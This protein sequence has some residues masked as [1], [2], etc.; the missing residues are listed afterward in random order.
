MS[1]LVSGYKLFSA[2]TIRDI[3]NYH[4]DNV[5]TAEIIFDNIKEFITLSPE[6]TIYYWNPFNKCF[7]SNDGKKSYN[8]LTTL[9]LSLFSVSIRSL[10]EADLTTLMTNLKIECTQSLLDKLD[11]SLSLREKKMMIFMESPNVR[12]FFTD[13]KFSSIENQLVLL[14]QNSFAFEL[15]VETDVMNFHNGIINLRTG[16]FRDRDPAIDKY[17]KCLPYDYKPRDMIDESIV[18][19]I[20]E[21][22][23]R[24]CNNDPAYYEYIMTWIGYCM[25]GDVGAEKYMVI[26]GEG[27]NAKSTIFNILNDIFPIYCTL[28]Q[29]NAFEEGCNNVHKILDQFNRPMRCVYKDEISQKNKIDDALIKQLVSG[30]I[31]AEVLFATTKSWKSHAKITMLGNY[32]PVIDS[33]YASTRRF[34]LAKFTSKFVGKKEMDELHKEGVKNVFLADIFF[35]KKFKQEKYRDAFVHIVLEFCKKFYDN[36]ATGNKDDMFPIP[37]EQELI[38]HNIEKIQESPI[39][40]YLKAHYI[41]TKDSIDYV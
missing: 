41:I 32:V 2:A 8:K 39:Q 28:T 25:T 33:H 12:I 13:N 27:S 11:D 15:D 34:M 10:S 3:I 19:E 31:S 4:R 38:T 14:L 24:I 23:L 26:W 21:V 37:E 7:I 16:E 1:S 35:V 20:K 18:D 9:L 29:K 17:S 36:A 5:K 6:G 40:Q 22:F 30:N